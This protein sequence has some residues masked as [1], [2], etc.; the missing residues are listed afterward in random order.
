MTKRFVRSLSIMLLLLAALCWPSTSPAQGTRIS[1]NQLSGYRDLTQAISN[2]TG[3]SLTVQL[4]DGINP[5][6]SSVLTISTPCHL[7]LGNNTIT[8]TMTDPGVSS[9][10]I[11]VTSDNVEIEGQGPASLITQGAAANIETA[12]F[13]GAHKNIRIHGIKID[14]ND[15]NQT[16]TG[17]YYTSIRSAAGSADI[18][19]YDN[20]FTRGGDRAIDLR[21]ANRVWI[22]HNYFHQTGLTVAGVANRG[23]NSVSVDVDGTTVSTDC[24]LVDNLVEEQGDAFACAHALRVHVRGNTIRGRADF[25]N[26]PMSVEAGF[27]ITGDQ[28]VEFVG[29]HAINVRGPQMACDG[30]NLSGTN[31][32]T[33]DFNA[34][35]NVFTATAASLASSDPRVSCSGVGLSSGQMANVAFTGNTFDGVRLSAGSI[36]NF[37]V[38][39]GGFHNILSNAA[40]GIAIDVEQNANGVMKLVSITGTA[41]STDNATLVTTVNVGNQVT[42]CV[43]CVYADNPVDSTV[44]NDITFQGSSD[45][46]NWM[47][48]KWN[49]VGGANIPGNSKDEKAASVSSCTTASAAG[50]TCATTLTWTT[51]FADTSY[52]P[53]C[54]ITAVGAGVPY[55]IQVSITSG[56]AISATIANLT[57][58]AASGTIGCYARHK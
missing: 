44:T 48:R 11:N 42:A 47:V 1:P 29:N 30:S 46:T 18:R 20:E 31:Y 38:S 26:T 36:Y 15:T 22:K 41:F 4:A 14:W 51:P 27:D 49:G 23:G 58:V 2:C 19:I 35:D 37:K 28:D 8:C 10:C 43:S 33:R 3:L 7:V 24:W 25:G 12:I 45:F 17:G 16:A 32:V 21:G 5:N 50:S 53:V 34:A 39:G 52:V 57:A 55:V 54:N 56:S 13:L 9:G 6:L 40:L